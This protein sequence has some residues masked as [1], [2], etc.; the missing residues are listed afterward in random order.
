MADIKYLFTGALS[1][2]NQIASCK[3]SMGTENPEAEEK[4]DLPESYD[5]REKFPKCVQPVSDIGGDKNCSSS[6]AMATLSASQDRICMASNQTVKL[7]AQELVDCDASQYGCDGGYAN[8]VLNWGRK[9]GFISEECMPYTGKQQECD[10]DHDD[11]NECRV[12][13][14]VYK[15]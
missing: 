9:K 10:V 13:G 3:T 7:A 11:T 14:Q 2:T 5:W 8:K 4:I 1:D 6:F 15:V 12:E